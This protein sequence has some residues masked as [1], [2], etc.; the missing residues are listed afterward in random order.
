MAVLLKSGLDWADDIIWGTE[1][2]IGPLVDIDVGSLDMLLVAS[3]YVGF[4]IDERVSSRPK[5][6]ALVLLW[7]SNPSWRSHPLWN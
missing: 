2:V 1:V 6:I 5:G 7:Q 4:E 3:G